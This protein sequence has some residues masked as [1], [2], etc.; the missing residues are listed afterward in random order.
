MALLARA[1]PRFL[2][3]AVVINL[4][5]ST[6]ARIG[7]RFVVLRAA[8]P[9]ATLDQARVGLAYLAAT[10]ANNLMPARAGDLLFALELRRVAGFPLASALAAQLFEKVV[11]ILSLWMLVP[12]CLLLLDPGP[13]ARSGL[14]AFFF[15]GAL[16]LLS[17]L[18]LRILGEGLEWVGRAASRLGALKRSLEAAGR[19]ARPATLAR[20]ILWSSAQ[21]LSDIAMVMSVARSLGLDVGFG[22]GLLVYL[23]VNAASALP[24]T[25]GQ[26]GLIEGGAILALTTLGVPQTA[27]LALALLYHAAHLIPLTVI[28]L[29]PLMRLRLWNG[30]DAP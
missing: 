23:A 19:I 3:L 30:S 21:D 9:E 14:T 17:L 26:I 27:A 4:V 11:E 6:G 10:A 28:G 18:A 7:R 1:D 22:A 8:E 2:I 16:G 20:A 13:A 15:A 24:G 12:L 29:G 25:P 5:L